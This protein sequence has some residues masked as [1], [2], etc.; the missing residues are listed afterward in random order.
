MLMGD[1]IEGLVYYVNGVC[2]ICL[3]MLIGFTTMGSL[4]FCYGMLIVFMDVSG[5]F[6]GWLCITTRQQNP[7]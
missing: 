3:R 6:M 1:E 2:S 4:W 5:G 7:H